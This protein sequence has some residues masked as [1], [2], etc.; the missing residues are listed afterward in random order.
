[1]GRTYRAVELLSRKGT[2]VFDS[3]QPREGAALGGGESLVTRAIEPGLDAYLLWVLLG[4]TKQNRD[5]R[6]TSCFEL[7]VCSLLLTKVLRMIQCG[8]GRRS[9]SSLDPLSAEGF[10]ELSWDCGDSAC[11]LIAKASLFRSS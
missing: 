10:A 8:A 4:A 11:F 9:R 6:V 1:M 3:W 5:M 7:H 2:L